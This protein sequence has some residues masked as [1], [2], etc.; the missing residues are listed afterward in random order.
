MSY[1]YT[2]KVA[3]QILHPGNGLH[4]TVFSARKFTK[5]NLVLSTV[6]LNYI[7]APPIDSVWE[8]LSMLHLGESSWL[9][10]FMDKI[11][12][13]IQPAGLQVSMA[14]GR[15]R[16]RLQWHQSPDLTQGLGLLGFHSPGAFAI[17]L[18]QQVFQ[19]ADLSDRSKALETH[20]PGGKSSQTQS[21]PSQ[22]ASVFLM[23]TRR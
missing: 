18:F 3:S 6:G 19:T 20:S 9:V 17:S 23:K 13:T 14:E 11:N 10:K 21:A 7:T 15:G 1:R 5:I 4:G 8:L 16:A 2:H 12:Q 22:E